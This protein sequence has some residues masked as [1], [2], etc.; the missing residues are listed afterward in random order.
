M[1]SCTVG[2]GRVSACWALCFI[3]YKLSAASPRPDAAPRPGREAGGCPE[4]KSRSAHPV[5]KCWDAWAVA[6]RLC[7]LLVAHRILGLCY[8]FYPSKVK[9]AEV[10]QDPLNE[11]LPILSRPVYLLR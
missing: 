10:L 8:T 2:P 1:H 3:Y 5:V 4:T 6:C 11:S 9:A 7:G